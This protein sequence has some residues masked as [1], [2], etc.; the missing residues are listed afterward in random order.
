MCQIEFNWV[1]KHFIPWSLVHRH[2]ISLVQNIKWIY[3]SQFGCFIS[4]ENEG[5]KE[6]DHLKQAIHIYICNFLS[7]LEG[8]N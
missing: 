4:I 1:L 3:R 5:G 7:Q 8:W 6:L 2:K